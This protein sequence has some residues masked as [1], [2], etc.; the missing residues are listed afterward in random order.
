MRN[1]NF[2]C[3]LLQARHEPAKQKRRGDRACELSEHEPWRVR[4]TDTRK[5]VRESA[6]KGHGRVRKRCRRR[7][8]ICGRDVAPNGEGHRIRAQPGTSPN[9]GQESKRSDEFTEYLRRPA[10][11]VAGERKQGQLKHQMSGN[12]SEDGS[13]D[14]GKDVRGS[15]APGDSSFDCIRQR[16]RRIKVGAGDGA[17]AKNQGDKGRACRQRIGEQRDSSVAARELLRHDA[18]ADHRGKEKGS[19]DSFRSQPPG[20]RHGLVSL[21]C[22]FTRAQKRT[23]FVRKFAKYNR[24]SEYTGPCLKRKLI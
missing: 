1:N 7:E 16:D 5:R 14:L 23:P 3:C 21:Y 15:L 10:P 18:G 4:R 22:I 8:P 12:R 20:E 11:N 6:G 17:E 19:S 24:A 13:S 2:R 9:D